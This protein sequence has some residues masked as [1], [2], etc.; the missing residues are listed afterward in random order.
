MKCIY[1]LSIIDITSYKSI[2]YMVPTNLIPLHNLLHVILSNTC[3]LNLI[4]LC[5]G[6]LYTI[7]PMN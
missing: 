1:V 2:S 6:H 7:L 5:Q 3:T 4:C